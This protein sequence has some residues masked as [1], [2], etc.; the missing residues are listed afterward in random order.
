MGRFHAGYGLGREVG[1]FLRLVDLVGEFL[2]VEA[3]FGDAGGFGAGGG[4]EGEEFVVE[5]GEFS[6]FVGEVGEGCVVGILECWSVVRQGLVDFHTYF[7][8]LLFSLQVLDLC[9]LRFQRRFD[10][11]ELL[12]CRSEITTCLLGFQ[13]C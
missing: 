4:F 13:P 5:A 1:F 8:L 10:F 6:A 12:L 9:F 7:G 3:F 2:E 11:E